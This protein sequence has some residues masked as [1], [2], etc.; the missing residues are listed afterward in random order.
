MHDLK[1][2]TQRVPQVVLEHVDLAEI[3]GPTKSLRNGNYKGN[4]AVR[5]ANCPV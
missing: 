2:Y 4:E 3:I 1:I 5:A